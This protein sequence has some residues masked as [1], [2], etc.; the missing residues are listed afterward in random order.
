M[1]AW[2]SLREG[3]SEEEGERQGE[4]QG[5][6]GRE[7]EGERR[8]EGMREREKRRNRALFLVCKMTT[9]PGIRHAARAHRDRARI[10]IARSNLNSRGRQESSKCTARVR[11]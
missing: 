8:S 10:Q 6:G 11:D 7:K 2:K 3:V 4:R 9:S 5:D 1:S